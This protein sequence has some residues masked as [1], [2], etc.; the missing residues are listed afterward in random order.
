[1]V[2]IHSP[3]NVNAQDSAISQDWKGNNEAEQQTEQEQSSEQNGQTVSGD[4]S[5]ASGNSL[6]CQDQGNSDGSSLSTG[7]CNSGEI[8]APN[9]PPGTLGVITE[10]NIGGRLIVTDVEDQTVSEVPFKVPSDQHRF[11]ITRDHH[12]TLRVIPNSPSTITFQSN[13]C[14]PPTPP[15]DFCGGVMRLPVATV[16]VVIR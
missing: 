12:Y 13:Y 14:L 2:S 3:L 1:M 10:S 4:N 16:T 6:F 5:I 8:I 11:Q 15:S 7:M 9:I